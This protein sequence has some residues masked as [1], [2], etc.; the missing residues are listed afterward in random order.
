[1]HHKE[2]NIDWCMEYWQSRLIG[3]DH[4]AQVKQDLLA[5]SPDGRL[6]LLVWDDKGMG[7][8][9]RNSINVTCYFACLV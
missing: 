5:N 8:S 6:Y 7:V 2:L 4:T 3:W 1:M 9:R